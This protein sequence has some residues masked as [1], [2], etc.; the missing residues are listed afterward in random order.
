MASYR[1]VQFLGY[2][3]PPQ[4]LACGSGEVHIYSPLPVL[5]PI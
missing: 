1:N 5:D 4:L 3:N 2:A